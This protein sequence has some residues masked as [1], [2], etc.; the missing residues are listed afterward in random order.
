MFVANVIVTNLVAFAMKSFTGDLRT[1]L[2]K[3]FFSRQDKCKSIE[4]YRKG[5]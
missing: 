3:T 5:V 4:N 1:R 2:R